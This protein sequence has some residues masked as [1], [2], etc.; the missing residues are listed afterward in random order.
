[1][2]LKKLPKIIESIIFRKMQ[3]IYK[4]QNNL[5]KQKQGED[6]YTWFQDIIKL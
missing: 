3:K 5:E 4:G 2:F 1:M 6:L